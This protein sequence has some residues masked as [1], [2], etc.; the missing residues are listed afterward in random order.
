MPARYNKALQLTK[1]M[2]KKNVTSNHPNDIKS[3]IESILSWSDEAVDSLERI[4]DKV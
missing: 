2:I 4:L 1:K 3:Q